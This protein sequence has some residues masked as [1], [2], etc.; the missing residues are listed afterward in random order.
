MWVDTSQ[1]LALCLPRGG[2]WFA[3]TLVQE[4]ELKLQPWPLRWELYLLCHLFFSFSV[5]DSR[6]QNLIRAFSPTP[7]NSNPIPLQRRKDEENNYDIP[8]IKSL[9]M[10]LFPPWKYDLLQYKLWDLLSVCSHLI[11]AM[12]FT[13][14]HFVQR[15]F[16]NRSSMSLASIRDRPTCSRETCTR[17][18]ARKRCM[19]IKCARC[20]GHFKA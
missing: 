9:V 7:I 17:L 12:V 16:A 2:L 13:G 11:T 3:L 8:G 14:S 10:S 18:I 5:S 1:L 4:P 15:L 6:Q 20:Q 19:C